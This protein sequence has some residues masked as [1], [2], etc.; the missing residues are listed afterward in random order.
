MDSKALEELPL[1]MLFGVDIS[2]FVHDTAHSQLLGTSKVLNGSVLTYLAESGEFCNFPTGIY[3]SALG[4]TLRAAYARFKVWLREEHLQATQPR[5]T[6]SRLNRKHRGMF[7][8]LASKAINGK[9]VSF[10]LASRCVAR[11]ERLGGACTELDKLVTT[12]I[13]S[14]CALLRH[15]DQC[16]VVMTQA[17]AQLMH[18]DGM[19]HLLSY[20]N[21]RKRS[22]ATKGRTLNRTCWS[23]LPKHHH[24]Q[25]ALDDALT[26]L[27]NPG[28][29]HLLAAE[30]F[31]GA[32]GRM[33]RLLAC[34]NHPFICFL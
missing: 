3:E 33:S 7:P 5:F 22:A 27:I 26:T 18:R 30:S 1:P 32:I 17:E 23:V 6:P 25:H 14:Y 28:T 19:L 20:A 8:C 9:R 12:T 11:V 2:R 15:F 16:S 4:T 13:W 24:L 31:V 34:T 29:Y 10:W 21:L